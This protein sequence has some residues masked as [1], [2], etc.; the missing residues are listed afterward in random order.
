MI[1]NLKWRKSSYIVSLH[2]ISYHIISHHITSHHIT[3]ITSYHIISYHIMS[4]H[5]M[6]CHVMSYHIISYHIISYHTTVWVF[7]QISSVLDS[8]YQMQKILQELGHS[9]KP[10]K[11]WYFFLFLLFNT[12]NNSNNRPLSWYAP[13]TINNNFKSSSSSK[14]S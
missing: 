10:E 14:F 6:S 11:L 9:D 8:R 2:I 4:C 12:A 13:A 5:V 7:R 1:C 3:V